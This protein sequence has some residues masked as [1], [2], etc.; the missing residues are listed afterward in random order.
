M[1]AAVDREEDR[2]VQDL[3]S[4]GLTAEEAEKTARWL[5]EEEII[6]RERVNEVFR[7]LRAIG[8]EGIIHRIEASLS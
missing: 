2:D 6:D 4:L 3:Q 7:V 1:Y 5:F 8:H